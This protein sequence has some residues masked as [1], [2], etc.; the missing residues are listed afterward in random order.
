[1]NHLGAG[2]EA[3]PVF[4]FFLSQSDYFSAMEEHFVSNLFSKVRTNVIYNQIIIVRV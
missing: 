2:G 4:Y 3:R 1:M